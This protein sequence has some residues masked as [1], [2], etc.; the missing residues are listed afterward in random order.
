[1]VPHAALAPRV[2]GLLSR[3]NSGKRQARNVRRD[4]VLAFTLTDAQHGVHFSHRTVSRSHVLG[5]KL[6][7]NPP[8]TH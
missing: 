3:D 8:N 7:F 5:V 4:N 1:M 6:A 2:A